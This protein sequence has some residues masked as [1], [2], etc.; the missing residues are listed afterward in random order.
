MPYSKSSSHGVS[1]MFHWVKVVVFGLLGIYLA[2]KILP[3]LL[4]ALLPGLSDGL[5]NL[6]A[7]INT[8]V[9]GLGEIFR[10]SIVIT[11]F[12][13]VVA[14]AIFSYVFSS[15]EKTGGQKGRM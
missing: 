15:M 7:V 3:T 10:P 13:V 8:Y 14:I 9:P 4:T 6:S 12:I 5:N 11:I 1:D 2:M